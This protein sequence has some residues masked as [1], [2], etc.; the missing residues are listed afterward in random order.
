MRAAR[1]RG[2]GINEPPG[3]MVVAGEG[4]GTDADEVV[5]GERVDGRRVGHYLSVAA[6][7]VEA[8]AAVAERKGTVTL[9]G[10]GGGGGGRHLAWGGS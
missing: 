6:V 9:V 3:S 10:L 5:H 7:G 8:G 2:G 1:W 4:G